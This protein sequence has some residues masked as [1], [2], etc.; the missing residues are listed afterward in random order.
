MASVEPS[1]STRPEGDPERAHA[2]LEVGRLL[3]ADLHPDAVLVAAARATARLLDVADVRLWLR[4][5]GAGVLRL[6]A[7]MPAGGAAAD[8]AIPLDDGLV[9]RIVRSEWPFVTPRATGQSPRF[10][11]WYGSRAR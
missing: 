10:R 2:L 8:L 11:H 7:R 6:G 5:A 4:D 1:A 3:A 9:A